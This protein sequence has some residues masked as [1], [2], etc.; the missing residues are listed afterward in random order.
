MS[1]LSQA[2]GAKPETD[3]FSNVGRTAW[4]R[5][6]FFASQTAYVAAALVAIMVVMSLLSPA[7]LSSARPT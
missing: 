1:D 7:F 4:W 3:D 6:G 5:R 2:S